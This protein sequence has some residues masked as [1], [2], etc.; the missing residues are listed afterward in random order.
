MRD[1]QRGEALAREHWVGLWFPPRGG[2]EDKAGIDAYLGR[3]DGYRSVQIKYDR[4]MA[5]TGN[6]YFEL[7]ERTKG[8]LGQ[9]W[10]PSPH[11]ASHFL[12]VCDEFGIL[13]PV[14]ALA[15]LVVG[16]RVSKILE[17]SIGVLVPIAE[18]KPVSEFSDWSA[19]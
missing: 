3:P 10:R 18:L 5:R 19:L 14:D 8:T 9:S 2:V 17:T 13:V 1:G 16:R 15:P 4:T 12:M 6:V 11:A 7:Y